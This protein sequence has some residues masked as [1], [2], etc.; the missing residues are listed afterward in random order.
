MPKNKNGLKILY[1]LLLFVSNITIAQ[2]CPP[3][4]PAGAPGCVPPDVYNSQFGTPQPKVIKQQWADRWGAIAG[5]N[6]KGILG[7]VTGKKNKRSAEKAALKECHYK[8]GKNC[9][10][11]LSYYNQCAAMI[12]GNTGFGFNNA[13]SEERAK[14]IG[15]QKCQASDSNCKVFYSACSMAEIESK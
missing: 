3:G 12:V 9:R 5:D 14:E 2:A 15:M 7:A 8:G 10:I 13:A 6:V 11:E 4:I 1:I